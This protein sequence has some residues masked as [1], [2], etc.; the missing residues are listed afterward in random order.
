MSRRIDTLTFFVL[1]TFLH[2]VLDLEDI[3]WGQ[4][5]AIAIGAMFIMLFFKWLDT[6]GEE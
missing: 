2:N 1:L 5:F 4:S 3:G 6:K